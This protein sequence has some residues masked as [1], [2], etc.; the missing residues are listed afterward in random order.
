V[1][2]EHRIIIQ[3]IVAELG[4]NTGLVYTILTENLSLQKVSAKF[5]P[6]LLME[7]QKDS[8]RKSLSTFLILQIMT[9][10][11]LRLSSPVTR[12]RFIATTLKPSFNLHRGSNQ[13]HHNQKKLGKFATM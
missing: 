11:L 1:L 12:L 9:Q 3:E 2:Q 10:N 5:V 7:K 13:N 8:G 6:K 4:I